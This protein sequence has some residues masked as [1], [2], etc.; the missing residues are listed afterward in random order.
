MNDQT[1]AGLLLAARLRLVANKGR[2]AQTPLTLGTRD[3]AV[4]GLGNE[5]ALLPRLGALRSALW[6]LAALALLRDAV[7]RVLVTTGQ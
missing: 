7:V 4:S 3:A 1:D 5:D 2:F 6:L